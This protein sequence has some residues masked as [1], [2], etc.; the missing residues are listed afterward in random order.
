MVLFVAGALL[1]GTT[2]TELIS[3]GFIIEETKHRAPRAVK[4]HSTHWS[5]VDCYVIRVM[6]SRNVKEVF[7]KYDDNLGLR[8]I[9]KNEDNY[10]L[11]YL[12]QNGGNNQ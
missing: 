7:T 2:P 11:S 3:S 12:V 1:P 9:W 5:V 4:I 10:Y 8:S 6:N